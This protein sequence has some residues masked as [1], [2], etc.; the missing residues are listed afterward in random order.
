MRKWRL[1]KLMWLRQVL[2][3]ASSSPKTR[4]LILN[5][6]PG[7]FCCWTKTTPSAEFNIAIL[8][9]WCL[10]WC[11]EDSHL[12][13]WGQILSSWC[14]LGCLMGS[15]LISNIDLKKCT[16]KIL[17]CGKGHCT[18][19][20]WLQEIF[21]IPGSVFSNFFPVLLSVFTQ[22]AEHWAEWQSW[23]KFGASELR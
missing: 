14:V 22:N 15:R 23:A 16:S 20:T 5:P 17:T 9:V 7:K 19:Q 8:T 12:R 10:L 18:V 11:R 3:P 2:P 13:S 6:C 21:L 4:T 1:E